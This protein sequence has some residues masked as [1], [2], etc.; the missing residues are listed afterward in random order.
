MILVAMGWIWAS[1][2]G[3]SLARAFA[4]ERACWLAAERATCRLRHHREA[5]TR[6]LKAVEDEL[7]E[8]DAL[9]ARPHRPSP[10][11]REAWPVP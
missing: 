6:A 5:E 1:P 11:N 9:P 3:E 8:P 4:T 7:H 10:R 2:V